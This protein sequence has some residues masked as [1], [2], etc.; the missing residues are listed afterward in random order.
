MKKG[1]FGFYFFSLIFLVGCLSYS[2]EYQKANIRIV[3]HPME[4]Q[5]MQYVTGETQSVGSAWSLQEIGRQAANIYAR[6][7]WHDVTLLVEMMQQGQANFSGYGP[8]SQ[9]VVRVS[10]YK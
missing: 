4:V 2:T 3:T 8:S 7:G 10:V 5:G 1:L 6:N 9:S